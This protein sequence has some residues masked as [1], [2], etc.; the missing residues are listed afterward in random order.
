MKEAPPGVGTG[1]DRGLR[2]E[3]P[4]EWLSAASSPAARPC[5]CADETS[6]TVTKGA[7]SHSRGCSFTAITAAEVEVLRLGSAKDGFGFEKTVRLKGSAVA[8]TLRS[9]SVQ[10][11]FEIPLR[12]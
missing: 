11:E 5:G 8:G 3:G 7:S 2:S 4:P 12:I 1:S 10:A 9:K 6:S